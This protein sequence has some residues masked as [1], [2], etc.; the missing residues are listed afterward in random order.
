MSKKQVKPEWS[1][2]SLEKSRVKKEVLEFYSEW[3]SVVE[4]D[5]AKKGW[6]G[7]WQELVDKF[8]DYP[9]DLLPASVANALEFYVDLQ[10]AREGLNIGP[11]EAADG[12]I[13]FTDS[14]S[15]YFH[16]DN[17]QFQRKRQSDLANKKKTEKRERLY[18]LS[19][20]RAMIIASNNPLWNNVQIAEEIIEEDTFKQLSLRGLKRRIL[21]TF[22]DRN[23][24][25]N[26][27]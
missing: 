2:L 11:F 13:H 16:A 23:H 20:D 25:Q 21:R 3:E 5:F 27:K 9:D 4:A 18:A 7:T 14:I 26:R 24:R 8:G 17:E 22:P 15:F 1:R 6:A 19:L 12:A 10:D